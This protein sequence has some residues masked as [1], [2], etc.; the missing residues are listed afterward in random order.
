MT[1]DPVLTLNTPAPTAA[2]EASC[3]TPSSEGERR[4]TVW[5]DGD[6]PLCSAEIGLMRRLD[7]RGAIAFVDLS[8]PGVCP[9][10]RQAGLERLHAQPTGG[11]V[12]VGAAAFV[13]MWRQL[14]GLRLLALVAA[15]PPVLWLMERA[16][17]LFLTMRPGLQAMVRRAGQTGRAA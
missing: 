7:R 9:I 4:L 16:Y 2:P 15:W 14:P 3:G 10:D 1:P 11:P 6:C 12:V 8:T 5:Y 17:G 13:A